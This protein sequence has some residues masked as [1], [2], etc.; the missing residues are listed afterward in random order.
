MSLLH[1]KK[2][3]RFDRFYPNLIGNLGNPGDGIFVVQRLDNKRATFIFGYCDWKGNLALTKTLERYGINWD[4]QQ[5]IGL[6]RTHVDWLHGTIDLK[7]LV[8]ARLLKDH[9]LIRLEFEQERKEALA[10][11]ARL[12]LKHQQAERKRRA[13]SPAAKRRRELVN[14]RQRLKTQER[15]RERER[16]QAE[17]AA[18]MRHLATL[19]N[20]QMIAMRFAQAAIKTKYQAFAEAAVAGGYHGDL[21]RD[22][23]LPAEGAQAAG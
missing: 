4:G 15:R 7:T 2:E 3:R 23:G 18:A 16:Q 10:R 22:L 20:L 8:T 6:D 21:E 17:R 1:P 14:L 5:A 13:N 11:S 9:R 19:N 12:L